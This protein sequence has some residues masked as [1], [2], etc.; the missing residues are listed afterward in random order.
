MEITVEQIIEAIKKNP[1]LVGG[2]LPSISEDNAFKT[3]VD[4]KANIVFKE[5]IDEEV[6]KIHNQYDDDIFSVLGVRAGT[7]ENGGKQKTY[8][9]AKS[10]YKELD[11]LKKQ[12]DSLSKDEK[13]KQLETEI[14]RLKT[15]GGGKH[16]QEI[17]DAAKASWETEKT[18]LLKRVND[19]VSENETF[20]KQTS[21]KEAI[22]RIKL[23]PDVPESVQKMVL[24]NIESQLVSNSK[25]EGG[26][27]VFL[28]TDGKPLIDSTTYKT[29]D[30]FQVL[31]DL[32]AIKDISLKEN[33]GNGGGGASTEINGSIQTTK[34]E[35]KDQKKLILT[36]GTFKTQSE[37][38]KIAEKALIDSGVVRG[39]KEW[40]SMKN[41]AF[42]EHKVVDLPMQ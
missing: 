24:S 26:N 37:F 8:E 1:S 42:I 6:K 31:A 41:E 12:K 17:F 28:G 38:I 29:K 35:G 20:K 3:L 27:L 18:D 13:V 23:S 21:I 30:A 33:G 32:D 10:L 11:G 19:G 5:K 25:F 14:Q 39:D 4:N 2:I 16:V 40:D 7:D 15:E 22:S 36:G 9:F 34:V